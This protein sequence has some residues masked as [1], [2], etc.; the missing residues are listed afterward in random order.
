VAGL[1][2]AWPGRQKKHKMT[3]I[4]Q[5]DL[6][7]LSKVM[8]QDIMALKITKILNGTFFPERVRVSLKSISNQ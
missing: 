7:A 3:K 1:D 5:Y 2:S 4:R 8:I 6:I